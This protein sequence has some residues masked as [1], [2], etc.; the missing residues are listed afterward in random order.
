MQNVH[1]LVLTTFLNKFWS[2]NTKFLCFQGTH[3]KPKP[4]VISKNIKYIN[5]N[6]PQPLR[7]QTIETFIENKGYQKQQ[8]HNIK[9]IKNELPANPITEE[10]NPTTENE[11][12]KGKVCKLQSRGNQNSI[13]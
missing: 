12:L 6:E 5:F 7:K 1:K 8:D 3:I 2:K 9:T 13:F 4:P 11:E 10:K